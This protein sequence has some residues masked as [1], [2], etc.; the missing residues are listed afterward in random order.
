MAQLPPIRRQLVVPAGAELAFTVFTEEIGSWW[1]VDRLSVYGAG[2]S[3]AV[4]D[5]VVVERGP[6]GAEAVWGTI[7]DW[8]P[9]HGLRLTWHPGRGPEAASEVAVSFVEVAGGQTLVTLEHHGWERFEDPAAA[10]SEYNRGWPTV[11][12]QFLAG[13]EKASPDLEP[14]DGDTWVVLL[15]TAGPALAP[16]ER[17]FAHPDFGEHLAFLRRLDEAGLLVAAGSLDG[18]TG[19]GMTVARLPS[20]AQLAELT[21]RAQD[22]DQAVVRGLLQVRVRPWRVAL[23]GGA[24]PDI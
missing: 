17:L 14:G 4:R 21:R 16:G 6:D 2:A 20:P 19:E 11:L 1:P 15:H 22:E 24:D 9:P 10:R 23:V 5:G 7:L 8:E 13:T 18:R 3:V 12:D